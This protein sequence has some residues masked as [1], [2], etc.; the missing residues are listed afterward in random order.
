VE[1]ALRYF[2]SDFTVNMVGRRLFRICASSDKAMPGPKW[3]PCLTPSLVFCKRGLLLE[4]KR[5]TIEAKETC[6]TST[7][8]HRRLLSQS[9]LTMTI[10]LSLSPTHRETSLARLLHS[11]K[12]VSQ[13]K[14]RYAGSTTKKATALITGYGINNWSKKFKKNKTISRARR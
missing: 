12:V 5:P 1:N 9:P 8:A 2:L 7:L 10:E 4:G 3:S 6:L 14:L 11:E 13:D